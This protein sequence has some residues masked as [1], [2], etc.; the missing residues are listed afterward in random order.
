MLKRAARVAGWAGLCLAAGVAVTR[1][2]ARRP[3]ERAFRLVN[4]GAGDAVDR[5]FGWGTELGSI[6]ASAAAAAVLAAT[7]H[8]RAAARGLGAASVAWVAGQGLKE[9]FPRLRPYQAEGAAV[10]LLVAPPRG[11]SWPSS[12]PAVLSA[13]LTVAGRELGLPVRARAALGALG[14]AVGFSR[15]YVGVHYPGDV[16]GGLSMGRLVA[17]ALSEAPGSSWRLRPPQ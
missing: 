1:G 4:R 3:D 6:W 9:L 5:L 12:H 17:D 11:R 10:R 8:R 14:A 7:G 15:T 13:F 16:L 2:H